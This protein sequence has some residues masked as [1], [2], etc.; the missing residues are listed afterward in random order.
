MKELELL[1]PVEPE[2][3]PELLDEA[4]VPE[5]DEAPVPELDDPP[6]RLLDDAP[7]PEL[8]EAPVPVLDD[9]PVLEPAVELLL[10]PVVV[11]AEVVLMPV[12]LPVLPP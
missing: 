1:L 3:D 4:P 12:P 10:A 9:A 2:L 6:V 8:D 5:L 11:P 7:V